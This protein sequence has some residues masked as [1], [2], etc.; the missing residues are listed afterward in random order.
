MANQNKVT[1]TQREITNIFFKTIQSQGFEISERKFGEYQ[2]HVAVRN[3][4][5]EEFTVRLSIVHGD[6]FGMFREDADESN[7]N[8]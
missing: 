4:E 1:T 5:G 3:V 7:T 6:V 8:S 2:K